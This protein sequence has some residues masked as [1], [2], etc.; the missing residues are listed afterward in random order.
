MMTRAGSSAPSFV[1]SWQ[2]QSW[3]LRIL[4]GFLGLTFLYAG[5]Q[6]FADPGFLHAGTPDFIGQQ[7]KAFAQGSPIRPLL[8]TAGH[9]PVLTGVVVALSEIVVGVA[10]LAG[11][12]PAA[13]ASFGLALNLVLFLSASWHVRPYFLGSDS[14]YAVAWIAY[15]AGILQQRRKDAAKVAAR[16]SH[17]PRHQRPTAGEPIG[18]REMIRSALVGVAAVV[19]GGLAFGLEGK[20][21]VSADP[22]PPL[23]SPSAAAP[24]GT[25]AGIA[26]T[27]IGSLDAIPVGGALNF[28]DPA[29]GPATLVRLS[30]SHVAAFSRVCTHA[31]CLVDYDNGSRLLVCPCHGAEFD[32][33]RGAAVVAGPAPSPLTRVPVRI[34]QTGTVVANS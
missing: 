1:R 22:P 21:K 11:V 18:R 33:S 13:M 15:L 5:L 2:Q 17:G 20:E 27:R 31:G 4:R 14:I 10:T 6:K 32:P 8:T 19:V 9:A 29:L 7:L 30:K 23:A 24:S 26:G 3:P 12:A 28:N 25:P 16:R 34:D